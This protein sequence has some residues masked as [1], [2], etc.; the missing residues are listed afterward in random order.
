MLTNLITQQHVLIIGGGNVGLSFALLLAH[1]GISSTLL[2]KNAYPT[3]NPDED[4]DKIHYLDS[5]NMA[6]SRRTVQIYQAIGLWDALQR[7]ACRIDRVKISENN[8]FGKATLNKEEEKVESF[9]QVMENSWLGRTLLLAVQQNPHIKLINN[10]TV[11][12]IQ[13][14]STNVT[15]K[16]YQQD[17][18]E[19][20]LT[21]DLLVA[22]DGQNSPCRDL[23]GVSASFHDYGQMAIVGTAI[24]DTPHQHTAIERFC[25]QGLIAVLPLTDSVDNN[26]NHHYR[27]SVVWVCEKGEEQTF[28]DNEAHFLQTL[29]QMFGTQAGTFLQAGRRS[30]FPLVKILAERQVVG[31]CVLM[32]NSAHTLHPV[33]G[34]GFNLCM[35]DADTL[36]KMLAQ[37]V[38]R[39]QDIGDLSLLQQYEKRRKTDQKRVTFFCDSVVYGF[40]HP[41]PVVKMVRNV[42]LIAFDKIPFVKPMV[43][44]FAM[45]LK[46]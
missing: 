25:Q 37:Q 34:Q 31:R 10:A 46:S 28:L 11:S 14:T 27:R 6:L 39:G 26:G 43:A 18:V 19:Q 24:T 13:Q 36:A 38:M 4:I 16:F 8:S 22:C 7:H 23:L 12:D 9:G 45:G 17:K 15:I 41:N 40:T 29:Q 5:R 20:Q 44:R 35:R 42:G 33:A 3:M 21:A 32:G 1:Y 30:A 2:E